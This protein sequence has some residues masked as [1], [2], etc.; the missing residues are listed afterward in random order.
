MNKNVLWDQPFWSNTI[1][2]APIH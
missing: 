2:N 1:K